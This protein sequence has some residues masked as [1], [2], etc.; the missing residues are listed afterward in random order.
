MSKKRLDFDLQTLYAQNP[1]RFWPELLELLHRTVREFTA[2]DIEQGAEVLQFADFLQAVLRDVHELRAFSLILGCNVALTSG[3]IEDIKSRAN[4]ELVDSVAELELVLADASQAA[5]SISELCSTMAQVGQALRSDDQTCELF[6]VVELAARL[7]RRTH[8]H[9]QIEVGAI[10]TV[11]VAAPKTALMQAVSNL[12][13]NGVQATAG[14]ADARIRFEAWCASD[15][16]FL[17]VVDNGPGLGDNP[18]RF[19]ESFETTKVDG[20]G[21]GLAVVR[22]LARAWQGA[23]DAENADQGGARFVLTIPLQMDSM[24]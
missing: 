24:R 4:P 2:E 16:A 1:G 12:V 21:L 23:V 7:L 6:E 10:P 3:L 13:R 18:E 8:P 5:N 15:F 17:S 22:D 20:L 11:Q 19:F 14:R 9:T